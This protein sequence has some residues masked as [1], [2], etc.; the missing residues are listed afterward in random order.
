VSIFHMT[1]FLGGAFGAT[2]ITSVIDYRTTASNAL[3]LLHRGGG[4]EF[5]DAFLVPL[6]ICGIALVLSLILHVP[7]PWEAGPAERAE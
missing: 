6:T 5:S 3:N 1:F 7:K 2:M 4:V